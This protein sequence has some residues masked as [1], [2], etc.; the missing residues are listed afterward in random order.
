MNGRERIR[1]VWQEYKR[2][3]LYQGK[4][5]PYSKNNIESVWI[6]LLHSPIPVFVVCFID[7]TVLDQTQRFCIENMQDPDKTLR[8]CIENMQV[9][10]QTGDSV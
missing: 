3:E 1:I 8:F 4:K 9:L 6:V 10:V 7:S 2:H 5:V